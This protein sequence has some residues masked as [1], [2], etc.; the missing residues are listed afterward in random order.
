MHFQRFWQIALILMFFIYFLQLCVESILKK[1]TNEFKEKYMQDKDIDPEEND[2]ETVREFDEKPAKMRTSNVSG[3]ISMFDKSPCAFY[4]EMYEYFGDSLAMQLPDMPELKCIVFKPT[5][6]EI[7]V[8]LTDPE[9]SK[10][11]EELLDEFMEQVKIEEEIERKRKEQEKYEKEKREREEQ[12]RLEKVQLEYN[13]RMA[14]HRQQLQLA[15]QRRARGEVLGSDDEIDIEGDNGAKSDNS[16]RSEEETPASGPADVSLA[17]KSTVSGP[18]QGIKLTITK[19]PR[20][21]LNLKQST[22]SP[23]SS[24]QQKDSKETK[25]RKRKQSFSEMF[26]YEDISDHEAGPSYLSTAFYSS[27]GE[28]SSDGGSGRKGL[29]LK[30]RK[31]EPPSD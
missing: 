29:T 1:H 24:H 11:G 16:D 25:S 17:V 10:S 7:S 13:R 30:L 28:G 20:L 26:D 19:R 8:S 2:L 4:N 27:E 23:H 21:T 3:F 5:P 22:P 18:G 15:Y 31:H 9:T 14:D 6:K 12:A